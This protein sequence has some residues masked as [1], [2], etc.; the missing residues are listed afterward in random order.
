[1]ISPGNTWCSVA[2]AACISSSRQVEHTAGQKKPLNTLQ[3]TTDSVT[4]YNTSKKTTGLYIILVH[5]YLLQYITEF[6]RALIHL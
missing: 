3:I 6:S 4:K 5:T 1:M 2:I